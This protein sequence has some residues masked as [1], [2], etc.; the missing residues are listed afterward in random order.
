M[1]LLNGKWISNIFVQEIP[2][3]T[4]NGANTSFTLTSNPIFTS[5]IKLYV[6]GILLIQG[7]HYSITG[8]AITMVTAPASGQTLYATY[9]RSI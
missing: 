2:S 1:A 7:T 4:V 3:G 8:N 6:N 5:A 9:I